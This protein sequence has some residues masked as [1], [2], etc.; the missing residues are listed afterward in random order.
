MTGRKATE[1]FAPPPDQLE[2]YLD[3]TSEEIARLVLCLLI[4][5]TLR[6]RLAVFR[7]NPLPEPL[8]SLEELGV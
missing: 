1:R 8:Q 7:E 5:E 3:L 6:E 2:A 4:E